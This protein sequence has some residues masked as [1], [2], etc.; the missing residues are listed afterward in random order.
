MNTKRP[1]EFYEG[2][3]GC[4]ICCS[5]K[6]KSPKGY[7][8]IKR[9]GKMG[10]LHRFMYEKHVGPIPEK[11]CVLHR[12]DNPACN[13]PR[14][15]FLGTQADNIR[16]MVNKDRQA[17]G[18]QTNSAFLTEAQV[19]EIFFTRG[20][21]QIIADIYNISMVQVSRIKRKQSWKHLWE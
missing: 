19:R 14:H 15:L 6:A 9:N 7:S 11:M 21:L 17:R 13:N 5:H 8:H 16:D 12:C 1:L 18:V 2:Y 20:T 4:W 3:R 10:L